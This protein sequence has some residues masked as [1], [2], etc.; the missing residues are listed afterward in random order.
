MTHAVS[1]VVRLARRRVDDHTR[2][3]DAIQL[4]EQARWM[5]DVLPQL[6][7]APDHAR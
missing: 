6:V 2:D 4:D 7:A 3:R 1:V 5:V